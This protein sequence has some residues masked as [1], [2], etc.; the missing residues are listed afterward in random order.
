VGCPVHGRLGRHKPRPHQQQ[1]RSNVVECYKSNDSFH[2]VET[3][4][5][6]SNCFDFVERTKFYDKLV[7]HCCRFWQQSLT[8]LRHCCWCGPGF[9]A[10]LYAAL[11][12][13]I[14]YEYMNKAQSNFNHRLRDNNTLGFVRPGVAVFNETF[15]SRE[16][17]RSVQ[18]YH[19]AWVLTPPP[20]TGTV[21]D[22]NAWLPWS[23]YRK[24]YLLW[25]YRPTSCVLWSS[26]VHKTRRVYKWCTQPC[27]RQ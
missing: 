14:F 23:S 7:R 8:L 18:Q 16:P 19:I 1:C 10:T 15:W 26:I 22:S 24:L 12:L 20:V 27:C 21:A 6:G 25:M 11:P 5:T 13:Y 4:W 2:E 9:T 17:A 3:N